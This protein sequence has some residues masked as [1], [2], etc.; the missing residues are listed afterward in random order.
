MQAIIEVQQLSQDWKPPFEKRRETRSLTVGEGEGFEP[1]K[2][3]SHLFKLRTIDGSRI[4]LE[5]NRLYTLK[6]Y[7]HPTERKIWMEMNAPISF[8]SLWDENG[9]TKTVTLRELRP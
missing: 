4:L 7:E 3:G 1:M 8:S 6:G 9:I 2:D 5:Y